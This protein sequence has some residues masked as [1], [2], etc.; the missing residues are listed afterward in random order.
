LSGADVPFAVSPS[1]GKYAATTAGAGMHYCMMHLV[2]TQVRM[3]FWHAR[4]QFEELMG[5]AIIPQLSAITIR[6]YLNERGEY[7]SAIH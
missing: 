2:K 3:P 4:S 1:V 6:S 5:H 7:G